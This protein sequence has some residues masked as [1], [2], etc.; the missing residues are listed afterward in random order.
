MT[1]EDDLVVSEVLSPGPV[2][3][4]LPDELIQHI[5]LFLDMLPLIRCRQ[6]CKRFYELSELPALWRSAY[7]TT[8]R[9]NANDIEKALRLPLTSYPW[10]SE[11]HRRVVDDVSTGLA[12]DQVIAT[13][14]N[15]IRRFEPL[16][17]YGYD[18]KDKLLRILNTTRDDAHDVLARR[19]WTNEMLGTIERWEGLKIWKAAFQ[20]KTSDVPD[21]PIEHAMAVFDHFTLD[22]IPMTL[23]EMDSYLDDI[24]AR[25][26]SANPEAASYSIRDRAVTLLS[27]LRGHSILGAL[28]LEHDTF[29]QLQ[30]NLITVALTEHQ[31]QA[32]PLV[33][34]TIYSAIARRLAI[35][36]APCNFPLVVHVVVQA[37]EGTTLSGTPHSSAASQ[38]DEEQEKRMF[39]SP[40]DSA[41]EVPYAT[42]TN[43]MTE[44][45]IPRSQ[46]EAHLEPMSASSLIER[47]TR[48]ILRSLR[49]KPDAAPVLSM[50]CSEAQAH[51]SAEREDSCATHIRPARLYLAALWG[52]NLFTPPDAFVGGAVELLRCID[53]EVPGDVLFVDETRMRD[54][55]LDAVDGRFWEG[56]NRVRLEDGEGA[57]AQRRYGGA[58][59]GVKYRIG[60][61]FKHRRYGYIAAIRGWDRRCQMGER[62]IQAM[63][64]DGLP[65]GRE[66]CFYNSVVAAV[67]GDR[68]VAEENI[69]ILDLRGNEMPEGFGEIAGKWFLRWDMEKGE[70]V[71]NV[72]DQW[73]DD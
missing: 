70:F 20:S 25:F 61:V 45:N 16:L 8:Y 47:T 36:A 22:R 1:P 38:E 14:T 17:Q 18:C 27:Y 3:L 31:H 58:N 2:L 67:V 59:G 72:R 10:R 37:P 49:E 62:W 34:A 12:I 71:S 15:R 21:P 4:G 56:V 63:N 65:G 51:L 42:M 29:V 7:V 68:Y 39:L 11:L 5:F 6:V 60:Q 48:N 50:L 57:T 53:G 41:S 28:L 23:S 33:A 35:P 46:Q 9:Y 66:Q 43:R 24:A 55:L 73:P 13:Q 32:L 52:L 26:T 69:E 64:V 30:N 54:V 19:Y 44:W 40:F